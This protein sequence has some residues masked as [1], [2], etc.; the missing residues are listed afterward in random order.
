MFTQEDSTRLEIDYQ[1]VFFNLR[2]ASGQDIPFLS[3]FD[4]IVFI[5]LWKSISP[6]HSL[7]KEMH[8]NKRSIS[9]KA[10]LQGRPTISLE[11]LVLHAGSSE[12]S[13]QASNLSD[14]HKSTESMK[15]DFQWQSV[16]QR[17][18]R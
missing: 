16:W 17:T 9:T 2:L 10:G 15:K 14:Y 13:W 6:F 4:G 18:E 11:L 7:L 1:A 3:G 12:G 5:D 8:E